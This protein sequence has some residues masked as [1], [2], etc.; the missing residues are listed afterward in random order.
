LGLLTVW[1]LAV[2]LAILVITVA[3]AVEGTRSR[4]IYA[5]PWTAHAGAAPAADPMHR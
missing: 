5:A 1:R 2:A 3:A 4:Q